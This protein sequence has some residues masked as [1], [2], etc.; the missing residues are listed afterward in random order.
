MRCACALALVLAAASLASSAFAQSTGDSSLRL[1]LEQQQSALDLALRH[2]G[3][4]NRRADA[5]AADARRIEAL[6][7]RQRLEYQQLE[8]EQWQRQRALERSA[9]LPADDG[10]RRS[11]ELQRDLFRQE[12]D[13]QIMRFQLDQHRLEQSITLRPLQPP[14]IPGTLRLP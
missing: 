4:T 11:V 5:M 8:I 13:L 1:E 6:Q 14:P 10:G 12:R 3:L 9:A 7:L 2:H